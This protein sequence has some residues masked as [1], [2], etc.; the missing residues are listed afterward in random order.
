MR[1]AT[2]WGVLATLSRE[3]WRSPLSPAP[4]AAMQLGGEADHH[5]LGLRQVWAD[6]AVRR[7]CAGGGED[8]HQEDQRQG[9]S[10][11]HKFVIKTCDTQNNDA[12]K[13]KSCALSLL[14]QGAS[15]LFTT[16]D[17]DFATRPH[18]RR[19]STASSRS[20]RAS[21]PTRWGRSASARPAS[22]PSASA[23]SRRTRGPRWPSTRGAR[24]EDGRPRH[25]HAA[26]LLQE[27]R[28]GVRQALPQLGGKIVD[29]ESY[30]TGG[31]T[32]TRRSRA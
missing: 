29:R 14:G 16:C 11:R 18:R 12:A 25:E 21:A 17:V 13:A 9:R 1:R 6:G 10:R 19:S 32:S 8:P 7:P 15:I 3:S 2:R 27:R 31:T 4:P 24:L 22:S 20:R 28:A 30:A 23:T 26:R 5:R